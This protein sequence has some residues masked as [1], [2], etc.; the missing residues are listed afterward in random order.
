MFFRAA[1]FVLEENVHSVIDISKSVSESRVRE[2]S[3]QTLWL[4]SKYFSSIEAITNT[5]LDI[6]NQRVFPE[7]T[8]FYED[9]NMRTTFVSTLS[10]LLWY[11]C[12]CLTS[13]YLMLTY[14]V[15]AHTP[16]FF[17]TKSH[18]QSFTAVV[19]TYDRVDDLFVL[20]ERLSLV[21]SLSM[22]LVV[23]NNQRKSPPECEENS[24]F[25][26]DRLLL[27]WKSRN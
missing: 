17:R 26:R 12:S 14:Q 8:L 18:S 20:I 19:L 27:I 24:Y 4:Y 11:I 13:I 22:I 9:W 23:W 6:L 3:S 10:L 7:N 1:L 16:F 5:T 25:Y 2:M 21:P 15:A